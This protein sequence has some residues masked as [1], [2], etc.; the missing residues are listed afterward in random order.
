[1]TRVLALTGLLAF[2]AGCGPKLWLRP[3]DFE[4]HAPEHLRVHIT[5]KDTPTYFYDEYPAFSCANL[6]ARKS[7][8]ILPAGQTIVV[9]PWSGR[10]L[11]EGLTDE[12][13]DLV[14]IHVSR[15][16]TQLIPGSAIARPGTAGFDALARLGRPA[17]IFGRGT[18]EDVTVL[19]DGKTLQ[20]PKGTPV[21]V[22]GDSSSMGKVAALEDGQVIWSRFLMISE[23][24]NWRDQDAFNQ[25]CLALGRTVSSFPALPGITA[26]V[27]SLD[28]AK[29]HVYQLTVYAPKLV[30]VPAA[31]GAAFRYL[32]SEPTGST[33]LRSQ[34]L[35]VS[36]NIMGDPNRQLLVKPTGRVVDVG[37]VRA[38]ELEI[39]YS[40]FPCFFDASLPQ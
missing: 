29:N 2:L 4:P 35:L 26:L 38:V 31:D 7:E 13:R 32:F 21:T 6:Q 34:K 33:V 1:M 3:A 15:E 18:P 28:Q 14:P 9:E 11:L 19:R 5:V 16:G 24:P 8:K 23:D 10:W 22:L 17:V 12:C 20:L 37:L 36:R 40:N 39:V 25:R 27:A 30:A